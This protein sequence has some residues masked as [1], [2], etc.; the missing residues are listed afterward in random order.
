MEVEFIGIGKQHK[1][2]LFSA[3]PNEGYGLHNAHDKDPGGIDYKEFGWKYKKYIY[4]KILPQRHHYDGNAVYDDPGRFTGNKKEKP[5]INLYIYNSEDGSPTNSDDGKYD[6]TSQKMKRKRRKMKQKSK[7]QIYKYQDPYD[8]YEPVGSRNGYAD[9]TES[10]VADET[11]ENVKE[12][13]ERVSKDQQGS[14]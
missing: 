5:N 13:H 12:N 7:S 6:D 1:I 3:G 4:P 8:I 11:I 14:L 9:G 10:K 2:L